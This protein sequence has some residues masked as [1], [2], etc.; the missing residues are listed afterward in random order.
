MRTALEKIDSLNFNAHC[1]RAHIY[2]KGFILQHNQ[3]LNLSAAGV[4]QRLFSD[5]KNIIFQKSYELLLLNI[6]N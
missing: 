4:P 6:F 2:K 1:V 3:K 5:F